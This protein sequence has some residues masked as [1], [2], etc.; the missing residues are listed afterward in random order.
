MKQVLIACVNHNSYKE[1]EVFLS[2]INTAAKRAEHLCHVEVLVADNSNKKEI[3]NSAHYSSILCHIYSVDNKGYIN[4]AQEAMLHYGAS[5]CQ[6][7]DFVIVSNVDISLSETFFIQL[8][9]LKTTNIGWIVPRIYTPST[10]TEENPYAIYRYSKFKLHILKCLYSVPFLLRCYVKTGH[11]IRSKQRQQQVA[12][13]QE[14][15]IYAGHGSILIFTKKFMQDI[16]PFNF[17][18]F[19]YGE[20]IYFAELALRHNLNT[21]FYPQI[22]VE[23][24]SAH[25]S[26]GML[27]VAKRCKYNYIAIQYLLN[28]FYTKS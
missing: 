15:K 8:L 6:Q 28:E 17:P 23:N 18:C 9:T 25:I 16:F 24:I 13:L 2:S 4:S 1:L 22:E 20:E 26:T 10:R 21:C 3:I 27:P 5:K 12:S 7:A 11:L 19:L 14:K